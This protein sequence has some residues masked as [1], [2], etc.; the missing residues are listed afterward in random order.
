MSRQ[1]TTPNGGLTRQPRKGERVAWRNGAKL[2]SHATVLRIEGNLCWIKPDDGGESAPF[3]WR[4]HDGSLNKL[5]EI[6]AEVH[7]S[8]PTNAVPQPE[9]A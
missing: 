6:V 7:Q 4:F 9:A 2:Y 3:L 8:E 5:A 1:S